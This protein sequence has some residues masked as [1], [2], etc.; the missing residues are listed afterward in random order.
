M[1]DPRGSINSTK[2]LD[3]QPFKA[4]RYDPER[5]NISMVLAPPYD[6]ISPEK[7]QKLYDRSP[8]NC[9]RLILNKKDPADTDQC[10]NYTRARDAF[11]EWQKKEIL[12]QEAQP[13]FYVYRQTF[14][15]PATGAIKNRSALLGRVRLEP[16]EKG[17]IVPHE[18]TL[19]GPKVDRMRLLKTVQT[20]FSPVFGLYEDKDSKVR[21]II[22]DPMNS[23]AVFTAE[24]DDKIVHTL[25]A[26][27]DPDVLAKLHKTLKSKKVYIADGHHR[28]ETALEYARQQREEKRLSDMVVFP[29]DYMY[30]ALVSFEDPGFI[31][32]PTH[33]ILT[34]N[35]LSGGEIIRRLEEYFKVE[36]VSL[37]KL[38]DM[39]AAHD[40]SGKTFGM[41]VEEGNFLLTMID[42]EKSKARMVSGKPAIWYDLNVNV[43][44]HLIL[45]ELLGL[46]EDRWESALKFE[47]T[48]DGAVAPVQKGEAIAAFLLQPPKIEMLEKMGAVGER[49]PQKSTYFYPKLATGVIFHS[50]KE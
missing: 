31:V 27:E 48:V 14:K 17:I 23:R 38:K 42:K 36:E 22:Q 24:D 16:F 4:W 1:Y 43:L 29:F 3:F 5:V 9:I 44:G 20:N 28:Y 15:N 37:A 10:N 39:T 8:F 25:W 6:V 30:M 13:C 26:I 49:M 21:G 35:G 46:K 41:V 47:H 11:Q 40:N 19:S 7:Q 45:A 12:I 2:H 32:L 33:R 34:R 50:H 18:K